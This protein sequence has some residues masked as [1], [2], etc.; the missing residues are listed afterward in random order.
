[1]LFD[2]CHNDSLMKMEGSP[3]LL[4]HLPFRGGSGSPYSADLSKILSDFSRTTVNVGGRGTEYGWFI[5]KRQAEAVKQELELMPENYIDF[6]VDAAEFA[7]SYISGAN[8]I[9]ILPVR[10][11]KD[12]G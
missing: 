10:L 5:R 9:D 7:K 11:R 6:L 4:K 1:M 3:Q 12:E 8:V 2:M